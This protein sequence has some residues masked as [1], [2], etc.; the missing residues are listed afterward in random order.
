[1]P[2]TPKIW[3]YAFTHNQAIRSLNKGMNADEMVEA[4]RLSAPTA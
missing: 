4:A 3:A 1:L 2:T